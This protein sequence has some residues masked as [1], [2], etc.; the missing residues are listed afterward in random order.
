MKAWYLRGSI[1]LC[2]VPALILAGCQGLKNGPTSATSFQLTVTAPTSGTGTVTS[3]P[4]GISCPGTCSASFPANSQVA[5][6]ATPIGSYSFSGWSGS[7]TG[8]SACSVTMAANESVTASFTAALGLTVA[9]TG[10]GTVMST[11]AGINCPGTCNANF[12]ANSQVSLTATATG[13]NSFVGWSGSCTGT[14]ACSL[15]MTANESVT[16]SF[17]AG[18]GLT[19][20]LAGAGTG[21]VVST[22]AGINCS[23]S[24][25]AVCTFTFAQNTPVTLTATP[26]TNDTFAG[27]SGGCTG[28]TSCSITLSAASNVTASFG[29]SLQNNINHIILF[30]QENRSLDHYFGYMRQYWADNG[31]PD[32]QFDGLP[33]F[34]PTSGIPPL[35][36]PAPS[37]PGCD[38]T[39]PPPAGCTVDPSVQIQSFHFASVCQENQSPFWNE[40]HNDWD[41]K[42]P[43][44]QP[45]E[46]NPPLNGFAFTAAYDARSLGYLDVNGVRS[47]GYF[48]GTDLN[49]YYYMASTFGTS[50][51]W[52]SPLMDRTQVNRMYLLAATSQGYAYPI[53]QGVNDDQVL[54]ATTIF[55]ALQNAGI[56]WK[57]YVNPVG[58][59]DSNGVQCNNDIS[60]ANSLCLI[61]ASY[62][63]MFAYEKTIINSAGQNPDLLLNIVPVSQFAIDAAAGTLPQFALVEPASNA[64]LDEHAADS[65]GYP[66]NVQE[67]AQYAAQTIINPLMQSPSWKD[68]ALILTYDEAG[69]F[70]DHVAPQPTAAPGNS[71]ADPYSPTDLN[72]AINDICTKTGELLGT[73]TCDFA[74]TGYRVPV[75]VISPYSLKNFVSHTTRDNTAVLAMVESRFGL[76]PLTGR[77]AAEPNMNE[78]FDFVNEPWAT[79]PTPP[80]QTIYQPQA[81]SPPPCDLTPPASWNEPPPPPPTLTVS[82]SG[83]GSVSSAPAGID[84]CTTNGGTCTASFTSGT[85]VTLTATAGAGDT[86]T[87]WSGGNCTGS[88]T[89]SITMT[90]ATAVT[91]TFTGTGPASASAPG[92]AQQ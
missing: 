62:I 2:V 14:S 76:S 87:G 16:A 69:G 29:G 13:T 19:V 70:Y 3:T 27:W 67:G 91:A 37:V 79:P 81:G 73:G 88:G 40:A 63:N 82:V 42:D 75:I 32:Q 30:A 7:C 28:T 9:L 12:P 5:L 22:P 44:D 72:P 90:E 43:A 49:Y 89:C 35:F 38:P 33:Q 92:K 60:D 59:Y 6:T 86:F 52:F 53:G 64:G 58:V 85:V 71:T 47:M 31:I 65:D 74:W 21:T 24:T 26:I 68:S 83:D 17:A 46:T 84:A 54:T 57:I 56:T 48:N 25:T 80:A 61:P 41:Y 55:Q 4:A 20:A 51:R 50:D 15:T 18:L 23:N 36:G 11:P 8:T 78:F 66:V 34:N 39:Q 10:S 45:A 1:A 77:D